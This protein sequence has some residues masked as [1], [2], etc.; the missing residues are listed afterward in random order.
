MV[1][2]SIQSP[3]T[4]PNLLEC[5]FEIPSPTP[6]IALTTFRLPLLIWKLRTVFSFFLGGF[7]CCK[8][9]FVFTRDAYLSFHCFKYFCVKIV[10]WICVQTKSMT[11]YDTEC[12]WAPW[13]PMLFKRFLLKLHENILFYQPQS[14]KKSQDLLNMVFSIWLALNFTKQYT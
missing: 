12:P 1:Y 10:H 4:V 7:V 2:I 3:K 13:L 8:Y 11:Y 9:F 5:P 14:F 6:S